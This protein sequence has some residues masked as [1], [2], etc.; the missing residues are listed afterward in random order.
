MGEQTAREFER[1]QNIIAN[2]EKRIEVLESKLDENN[3]I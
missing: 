1:L 2:L 3:N